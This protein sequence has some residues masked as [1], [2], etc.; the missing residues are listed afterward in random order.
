MKCCLLWLPKPWEICE[1]NTCWLHYLHGSFWLMNVTRW[2]DTF[3]LVISFINALW[4]TCMWQLGLF[5]VES[6]MGTVMVKQLKDLLGSFGLLNKVIT[7]V[8]DKRTNLGIM[9]IALKSK[10]SFVTCWIFQL[11][12]LELVGPYYV[13][14]NLVCQKW[15]WSL[16][17]SSKGS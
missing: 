8:K 12:L 4:Q 17:G 13:K 16:W 9:T 15:Q 6:T 14:S 11:H 5:I 2:Y 7:F 10:L 1:P 3:A